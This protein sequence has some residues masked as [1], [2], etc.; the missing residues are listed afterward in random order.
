[1]TA[2]GIHRGAEVSRLLA[3]IGEAGPGVSIVS[4]SGTGGVGKS[5]LV[6]H[7]IE[8]LQAR[9]EGLVVLK[10]DG[11]DKDR[12]HDFAGLVEQLAPR[13][14]PPP[15][16][17]RKDYFGHV[18]D[19]LELHRD[20]VSEAN[21]ELEK[22]GQP[23]EMRRTVSAMLRAGHTLNQALP[24][25]KDYFNAEFWGGDDGLAVAGL[26]A[27]WDLARGLDAV[28]DS[29]WVP[30]VVRDLVGVSMKNRVK[31]DL[32]AVTAEQLVLD[33]KAMT[34]GWSWRDTFKAT[35]AKVAGLE[36]AL[37]WFD[38]YE[39]IGPT[40]GSFL[41]SHLVPALA[42][43]ELPTVVLVA[44]RDDVR[45]TDASWSQHLD[46]SLTATIRLAPFDEAAALDYLAAAG[47]GPERAAAIWEMTQG[48]PFLLSLLAEEAADTE[49]GTVV[50]LQRFYE[51]TTRWMSPTQRD[52][53]E[54]ACYLPEVNEDTLERFFAPERTP[55]IQAW[56]Q[57]EASIRD[58]GAAQRRV[59]PLIRD[60][61][62]RYLESR[63][64]KKHREAL[65]RAQGAPPPG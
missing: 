23:D 31:R 29:T 46:R 59:R 15:A 55:V 39:A 16:D 54:K 34:T 12:V 50:F 57:R 14:M 65:A 38:D 43:G 37:L 41:V 22:A 18:R 60:K 20:V 47:V 32:F 45:D 36:R 1:M 63:S 19:V 21:R 2:D 51:R 42:G 8:E 6:N 61:V 3:A 49:S 17:P 27:A 35:Q 9:R 10:V 52:W 53:F 33:L 5:Y 25:T 26:D 13:R 11:S 40:L 56:F 24:F 30:G 28:R 7:V 4:I 62:L 44:G 48:F 64:P 58:P